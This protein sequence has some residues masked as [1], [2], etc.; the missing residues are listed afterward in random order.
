MGSDFG[1]SQEVP[2]LRRGSGR[3]RHRRDGRDEKL[4]VASNVTARLTDALRRATEEIPVEERRRLV[5]EVA[6]ILRD[7]GRAL[8]EDL[9]HTAQAWQQRQQAWLDLQEELQE[10]R[11]EAERFADEVQNSMEDCLDAGVRAA[12]AAA[13]DGALDDVL[14][15]DLE[16]PDEQP[17]DELEDLEDLEASELDARARLLEGV[18]DADRQQAL[19]EAA[20]R[21]A[22]FAEELE[23]QR[24]RMR[25]RVGVDG[26]EAPLTIAQQLEEE[27]LLEELVAEQTRSIMEVQREVERLQ[28]GGRQDSTEAQIWQQVAKTWLGLEEELSEVTE[29]LAGVKGS[30]GPRLL[31]GVEDVDRQAVLNEA[32][33]RAAL[34]AE[35]LDRQRQKMRRRERSGLPPALVAGQLLED[36]EALEKLTAEQAQGLADAQRALQLALDFGASGAAEAESWTH[37]AGMWKGTQDDLAVVEK[38]VQDATSAA[39]DD[40]CLW[41]VIACQRADQDGAATLDEEMRAKLLR[42]IEGI[43]DKSRRDALAEAVRRAAVFAEELEQQRGGL[44]RRKPR[45]AKAEMNEVLLAEMAS[46]HAQRLAS[47]QEELQRTRGIGEPGAAEADAWKQLVNVW[48]GLE[49]DL[50]AVSQGCEDRDDATVAAVAK[51]RAKLGKAIEGLRDDAERRA[52]LSL[53]MQLADNFSDKLGQERTILRHKRQPEDQQV[54]EKEDRLASLTAELESQMAHALKELETSKDFG[55]NGLVEAF[56]RV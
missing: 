44:R 28:G 45:E 24:Q 49:K 2:G 3:H 35:E 1:G 55:K 22:V 4:L 53:E 9:R 21:A 47:A 8:P 19:V 40:G 31:E 18:G 10:A 34:F 43:S 14:D 30:R 5:E 6:R 13:L 46:E 50:S 17:G 41:D 38:A 20:R 36:Q 48:T 37:I 26:T 39:I 7:G 27:K 25:K 12:R 15:D 23:R 32:A 16:D 33:R 29:E 52:V 42:A 56:G 11:K 51:A 54:L